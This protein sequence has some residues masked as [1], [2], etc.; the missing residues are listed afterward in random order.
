MVATTERGPANFPDKDTAPA[1]LKV[2]QRASSAWLPDSITD[3]PCQFSPGFLASSSSSSISCTM[4]RHSPSSVVR[5]KTSRRCFKFCSCTKRFMRASV[6][7]FSTKIAGCAPKR[8]MS[9]DM[10]GNEHYKW[11]SKPDH[12]HADVRFGSKADICNAPTHVRFTP[13]SDR[14]SGLRQTIMSALPPKADMC[15][16]LVHVG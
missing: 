11:D 9:N 7:R 1:R 13:N 15:G 16:A 4:R 5:V 10:S 12:L 8:G 2:P 3:F 6:R 14:K